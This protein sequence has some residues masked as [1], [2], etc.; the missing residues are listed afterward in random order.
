MINLKK[1]KD[2][3]GILGPINRRVKSGSALNTSVQEQY[4]NQ[5]VDAQLQTLLKPAVTVSSFEPL[6]EEYFTKKI[7]INSS[8]YWSQSLKK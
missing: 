4:S 3:Y 7:N 6:P 2:K 5:T 8:N 1:K